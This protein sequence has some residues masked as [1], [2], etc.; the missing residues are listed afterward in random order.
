[1]TIWIKACKDLIL[2]KLGYEWTYDDKAH[3][4]AL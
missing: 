3:L 4:L 2:V 1:M